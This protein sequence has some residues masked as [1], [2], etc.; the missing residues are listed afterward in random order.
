MGFGSSICVVFGSYN[1]PREY[2]FHHSPFGLSKALGKRSCKTEMVV[3]PFEIGFMSNF[4][5]FNECYEHSCCLLT[6]PS[7]KVLL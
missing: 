6:M 4:R 1:T 2:S 5:L 7:M 3:M